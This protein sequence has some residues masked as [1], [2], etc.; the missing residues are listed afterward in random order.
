M[1]GDGTA[2]LEQSAVLTVRGP[3]GVGLGHRWLIDG[4][5]GV[6]RGERHQIADDRDRGGDGAGQGVGAHSAVQGV[7]VC[8]QV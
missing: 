3:T 5:T 2:S 4:D 8:V 7:S 6:D 1:A